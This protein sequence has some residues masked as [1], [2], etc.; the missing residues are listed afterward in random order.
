MALVAVTRILNEDDIVEAFVRHHAAMVDHHLFLDNGSTDRTIEILQNLKDE[1]FRLTV[2]R[3]QTP[4]FSELSYNTSLFRQARLLFGASWV[5][6]LDSDEFLNVGGIPGSLS[7][8]LSS[9]SEETTSLSLP[10]VNYHD[11]PDDDPTQLVVPLR[12]RNRERVPL[13]PTFKLMLRGQLADGHAVIDAGQHAAVIDGEYVVGLE[14]HPLSLGHYFRRSAWQQISKTIIGHLKVAAAG[15]Q[16]TDQ[17]RS[18]HYKAL[19]ESLRDHPEQVFQSKFIDALHEEVEL[20]EDPFPYL[21]GPLRYTKADDPKLKAVR[22]LLAYA[23]QLAEN[24]GMF[25]DTNQGVRLQAEQAT[26][27]WTM[28]M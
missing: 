15:K 13:A 12:Q 3:N 27:D 19:F 18:S 6:F 10:V 16:E 2:L 17:N 24:H 14:D 20:V 23:Q 5:L 28:L 4:F 8:Y 26:S 9:M 21:G 1:G 25:I 7:D 22:V 11:L